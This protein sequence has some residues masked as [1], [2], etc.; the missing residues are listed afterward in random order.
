MA[1]A[2]NLSQLTRNWIQYLKNNSLVRGSDP[3]TGKLKYL[4]QPTTQ[5]LLDF[6]TLQRG[7]DPEQ[8]RAAIRQVVGNKSAQSAEPGQQKAIGGPKALP[9]PQ[10]AQPQGQQPQQPQQPARNNS[11]AEDIPYRE[12]QPG[13]PPALTGPKRKPRFKYRNKVQ[14]AFHAEQGQGMTLSEEDIEQIFR[15]LLAPKPKAAEPTGDEEPEENPEEVK[16]RR[17]EIFRQL[18]KTVREVMTPR[19]RKALWRALQ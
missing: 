6:F 12:V 1:T 4:K 8:V 13:Q 3:E 7:F 2:S 11:D 10:Q 5:D 9:A 16:A 18:K 15:I 19:Q 14:E 17:Q